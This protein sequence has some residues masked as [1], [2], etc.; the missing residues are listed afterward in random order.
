M[1]FIFLSVFR[2]ELVSVLPFSVSTHQVPCLAAGPLQDQLFVLCKLSSVE[3]ISPLDNAN[4]SPQCHNDV[5]ASSFGHKV[6]ASIRCGGSFYSRI[7]NRSAR[8]S[9][10][11]LHTLDLSRTVPWPK[12][13]VCRQAIRRGTVR[14][15]I[16][17]RTIDHL[18]HELLRLRSHGLS[19]RVEARALVEG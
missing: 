17:S 3:N 16:V 8:D 2:V 1:L 5:R 12:R 18:H 4:W 10:N 7:A 19:A 13:R 14:S 11:A 6:N 9:T 15:I